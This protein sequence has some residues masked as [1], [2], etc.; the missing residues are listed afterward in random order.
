MTKKDKAQNDGSKDG[1]EFAHMFTL[2]R[3]SSKAAALFGTMPE[4]E[5]K[6]RRENLK[7]RE[8]VESDGSLPF[9][10]LSLRVNGGKP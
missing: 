10:P 7:W 4:S 3:R 1:G 6:N 8:R 5:R 9:E 2:W